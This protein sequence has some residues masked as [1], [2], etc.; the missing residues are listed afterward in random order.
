MHELCPIA[1]PTIDRVRQG[2]FFRVTAI[3]SV[4]GQSN[5]L[6]GGLAGERR[7][8]WALGGLVWHAGYSIF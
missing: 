7:E 3:P 8:G 2:Y 6:N 1:P 5:F 4:L